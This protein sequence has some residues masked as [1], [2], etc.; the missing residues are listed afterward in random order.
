[1]KGATP[2]AV[3][4]P[5]SVLLASTLSVPVPVPGSPST[6][7]P[8]KPN[9]EP[10]TAFTDSQ[11]WKR[12]MPLLRTLERVRASV[13]G[14]P[15]TASVPLRF[16]GVR[17]VRVAI[18]LSGPRSTVPPTVPPSCQLKVSAPKLSSA[19]PTRVPPLMVTLS[20]PP[21][22]L[23]LPPMK[24]VLDRVMVS[25]PKPVTRLRSMMP[26]DM[27]KTLLSSFMSTRPMR[28]PVMTAR[29]PSSKKSTIWPL[30][31]VNV[32]MLSP[33]LSDWMMPPVIRKSSVPLPCWIVPLTM[34][35]LI[36]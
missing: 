34:P 21:L 29:S 13:P 27:S 12:A 26:P 17:L 33:W 32:S 6:S 28:P 9:I 24:A 36:T 14:P 25:L 1:M 2:P 18:S 8:S 19:L 15:V 3:P 30:V 31:M 23:I 20:V 35:P 16:A 10:L 4:K 22:T 7:T 11:L 5:I